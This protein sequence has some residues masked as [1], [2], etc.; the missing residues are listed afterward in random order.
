MLE[1]RQLRYV[2]AV[3]SH[4]SFQAAAKALNISQPVLSRAIQNLEDELGVSLF[5]RRTTG[6]RPT[7]AGFRLIERARTIID[8]ADRAVAELAQAARAE[9]GAVRLGITEAPLDH[10]ARLLFASFRAE[11]P[12]VDLTLSDMHAN[13]ILDRIR[14]G[15]LDVGYI[16]DELVP[17]GFEALRLWRQR[18]VAVLP[19]DHR[20]ATR[21]ALSWADLGGEPLITR[22]RSDARGYRDFL[23]ARLG[24]SAKIGLF[25]SSAQG[26]A[27]LVELHG[28]VTI[29][30]DG[31]V[32]ES[33]SI[34]VR[35]ILEESACLT[36]VLVWTP[37]TENPVFGRFLSFVRDRV[38]QP[39]APPAEAPS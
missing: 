10:R 14:D 12:K 33:K 17:P 20:L 6:T 21:G 29:L 9:S 4:R 7:P 37:Q 8:E 34:A 11:H 22:G 26:L 2:I 24:G 28:C 25:N 36:R 38:R 1:L 30:P 18:M 5:E 39:A 19:A 31:V 35:P 32:R 27:D 15:E 13:D 16:A 23:V 3:A